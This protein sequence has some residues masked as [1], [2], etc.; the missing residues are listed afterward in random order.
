MNTIKSMFKTP[1][2]AIISTAAIVLGLIL[3]A[4]S[5]T[6]AGL[7]LDARGDRIERA[8]EE[9]FYG[10][11]PGGQGAT[12]EVVDVFVPE[13]QPEAQ[14]NAPGTD[15]SAPAGQQVAETPQAQQ[16]PQ[17][18]QQPQTQPAPA[19]EA[20]LISQQKAEDIALA[21]AGIAR[22]SADRI[23]SHLEWDDGYQ[24]YEVSIYKDLYE[25]EYTIAADT[26]TIFE[27]DVD[28]IYD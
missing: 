27:K 13:T 11:L 21:D 2:R 3:L 6:F 19:S 25:Y 10:S 14:Q 8:I 12:D 17:A 7:Y 15:A 9:K 28:Y 26:G 20:K 16:A 4:T 23:Y 5:V 22:N 24:Q 1:K 18:Q